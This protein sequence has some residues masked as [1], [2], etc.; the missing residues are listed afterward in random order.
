M[1]GCP[2]LATF[3]QNAWVASYVAQ[4]RVS[5]DSSLWY[6]QGGTLS[7]VGVSLIQIFHAEC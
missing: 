5:E 2:I 7:V 3:F 1:L 4:L 6:L